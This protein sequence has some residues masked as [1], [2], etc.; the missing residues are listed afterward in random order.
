MKKIRPFLAALAI[1]LLAGSLLSP[2]P[3]ARAADHRDSPTADA[4]PEGDITD[5]FAFLDPNDPSQ[6]V[7]ILNVNPFTVPAESP[8]YR[9]SPEFLYQIKI[10]NRG[11]AVE[12]LVVQAVFHNVPTNQCASGQTIQVFGPATPVQVGVNNNLL[13][14]SPAVQGCTGSQILSQG[15]MQ[16]FAGLRDDP[17]ATDVGQLMRI[18]SNQQ[19]VFRDLPSTPLGHLRGRPV[20]ADGTSGVDGFGGFDVSSIAVRFPKSLV[21]GSTSRLFLWATVSAP[22]HLSLLPTAGLTA[23]ET[24]VQFQ[25]MG[26]QLFKTVFVPGSLREAFNASAPAH[27]LDNWS[28]LVPNALTGNDPSGNTIAARFD[29]LQQLGLDGLPNA[30]PLLLP[31]NFA[32]T[33]PNL[34]R[35]AL[36]PDVLR[37]DC[38]LLPSSA[39]P[40]A[41]ANGNGDPWF[42]IGQFG[43]QN[44]RRPA[45]DVTDILLRLARQLA[46]VDFAGSG[47]PGALQFP[48][49]R[50]I[51]AVLQ[52]TDFI[53]PDAQVA[54]VSNSG[55]DRMFL[56]QFP[57]LADPHPLPGNPGTIGFPAQQ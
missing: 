35:V 34:L 28:F 6:L 16:V 4:N 11:E 18:L 24:V 41:A 23:E 36:L 30:A 14:G 15:S 7:L 39:N 38:N 20:R 1:F 25:R 17:F 56:S 29:L 22:R 42:A 37:L 21:T 26:Q 49:D 10:G 31:R 2:L 9:F 43:L 40:G 53:K 13:P 32:N 48:A 51:F 33:N 50:R 47:R 54:D 5:F 8:T 44:G 27:D 19:D 3:P 45:D 55:N 46:D 57:F 12:N 52:G